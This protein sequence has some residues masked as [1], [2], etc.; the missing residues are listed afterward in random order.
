MNLPFHNLQIWNMTKHTNKQTN[1]KLRNKQ[2]YQNQVSLLYTVI[3]SC[4][5]M[6]L[7]ETLFSAT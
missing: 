2:G 6:S 1:N 5:K 7:I 3:S 4:S